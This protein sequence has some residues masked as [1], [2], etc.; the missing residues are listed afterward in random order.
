MRTT[1][2][3]DDALYT[4]VRTTAASRGATVTAFIEEALRAALARHHERAPSEPYRVQPWGG[5][6]VR[7]G[8]D[9]DDSAA[10]L[11]LMDDDARP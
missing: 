2:R 5:G 3:L 11:D 4:D 7:P 9:L 6:G 10:L 1:I 8:V